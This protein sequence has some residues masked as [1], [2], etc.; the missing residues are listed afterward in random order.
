MNRPHEAQRASVEDAMDGYAQSAAGHI[1][2]WGTGTHP[3]NQGWVS[4]YMQGSAAI[5]AAV[6]W[7]A[8]AVDA[9][10]IVAAAI[11]RNTASMQQCSSC[12]RPQ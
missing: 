11:D 12:P 10:Q 6:I 1:E 7:A 4:A 9:A 8:G 2:G 5:H 3:N